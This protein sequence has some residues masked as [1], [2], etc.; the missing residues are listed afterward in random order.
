VV[1]AVAGHVGGLEATS[2]TIWAPHVLEGILQLDL[3][4][5]GHTVLGDIGG[6]ELLSRTTLRPLGPS[7]LHGVGELVHAAKD[8]PAGLLGRTSTAWLACCL[9][10]QVSVTCFGCRLA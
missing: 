9:L 8:G 3:L 10:L 4:R 1:V 2:F 6:A 5:H 7:G